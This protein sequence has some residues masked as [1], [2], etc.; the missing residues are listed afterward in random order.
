MHTILQN[1]R[2]ADTFFISVEASSDNRSRYKVRVIRDMLKDPRNKLFFHFLVPVML[3]FE[4]INALFQAEE[5]DPQDLD[6][7]LRSYHLSL[8]R[9]LSDGNSNTLWS[10]A[11]VTL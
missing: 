8:K 11:G 5:A 9:R 7:E 6:K 4:R 1:W 10:T 3:E 2:G